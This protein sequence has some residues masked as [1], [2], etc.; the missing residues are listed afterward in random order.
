MDDKFGQRAIKVGSKVFLV[1]HQCQGDLL[2]TQL[3]FNCGQR[4]VR[5]EGLELKGMRLTLYQLRSC[6]VEWL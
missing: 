6:S 3:G 1:T 5:S 4:E 2:P